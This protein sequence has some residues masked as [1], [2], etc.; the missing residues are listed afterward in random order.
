MLWCLLHRRPAPCFSVGGLRKVS[1]QCWSCGCFCKAEWM[2]QR[3]PTVAALNE[4]AAEG[5]RQTSQAFLPSYSRWSRG[6]GDRAWYLA[7][8][9]RYQVYFATLSSCKPGHLQ[10]VTEPLCASA[11]SSAQWDRHFI[12]FLGELLEGNLESPLDCKDIKP[13]NPKGNKPWIL[14]GRVVAEAEVPILWP[15][16]AKSRFIGKDRDARKDRGQ[17]EKGATEDEMV[18]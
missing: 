12:R 10:Q 9:I 16:N 6:K 1:L 15:P 13:V 17:E 8:Y 5:L 4:R 3:A 14:T 11:S 2:H 7:E 18:G